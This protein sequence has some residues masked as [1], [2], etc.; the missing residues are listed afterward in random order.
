MEELEKYCQELFVPDVLEVSPFRAYRDRAKLDVVD[1]TELALPYDSLYSDSLPIGWTWINDLV[2]ERRVALPSSLLVSGR[3]KNDILFSARRGR[4]LFSSNGLA[5]SFSLTEAIL[6]ALCEKIER[7]AVKLAE[8]EISNPGRVVGANQPEFT[9]VDLATGS[10]RTMRLVDAVREAGFEIRALD[11]TSEVRVPT[12]VVRIMR[13]NR[14]HGL[15]DLY[16]SGSCAHTNAELAL[17]RAILEAVQTRVTSISG[18]REDLGV[19]ARSLGRHERPRPLS[20]GD[21]FWIRPHVPKKPFATVVD[22][23]ASSARE[24]LE[25]AVRRVTEAGFK[26]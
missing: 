25:F 10:E 19:K 3:E 11:I 16:A 21:A 23:K 6:H 17:N 1:P 22:C 4:K 7:H 14:L 13:T 5:G 2:T 20:K 15:E 18:A 8:Q 9:F 24:A 26:H 12:F